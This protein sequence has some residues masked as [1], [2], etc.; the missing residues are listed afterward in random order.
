MTSQQHRRKSSSIWTEENIEKA[1]EL[2]NDG[3]FSAEQIGKHFG[4][5]RMAV[6]GLANR[7]KDRF[8]RKTTAS[9]SP[10]KPRQP[11]QPAANQN[12]SAKIA[13]NWN[14][15]FFRRAVKPQ[16]VS[17]ASVSDMVKDWI[18]INGQPRQFPRGF[19]G[20]W[21]VIQNKM[22]ELGWE[23]KLVG[24]KY[25]MEKVGFTGRP[26]RLLRD[27][28]LAKIDA[29]LIANGQQPFLRREILEAAE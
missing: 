10:R 23:L 22:R 18:A 16:P 20:D 17:G 26:Q 15:S 5:S 8:K 21:I 29:V 28:V 3:S 9:V 14:S 2:W 27:A 11:R 4:V 7:H 6:I 12:I 19:S 1:L 24:S 13:P 25:E